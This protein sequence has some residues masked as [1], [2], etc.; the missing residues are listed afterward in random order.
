MAGG[1]GSAVAGL[2]IAA[3]GAQP[4]YWA[5]IRQVRYIAALDP[6]TAAAAEPVIATM[7]RQ[8][9]AVDS[10]DLG[11]STPTTDLPFGIPAAYWL[12]LRDYDPVSLAATLDQ[13]MLIV[14]GGRDYQATV[15]DD[16][17]RWRTG[18]AGRENVTIRVYD[19]DNHTFFPGTGPS[20]PADYDTLHHVD[21]AVVADIADWLRRTGSRPP[22]EDDRGGT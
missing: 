19:E 21:P 4:L 9:E 7:T 3:G 18:L 16:L 13:P 8:A 20:T 17:A 2:V 5:A 11:P 22:D 6:A 12:D 15:D 10:P 1:A 14:Q